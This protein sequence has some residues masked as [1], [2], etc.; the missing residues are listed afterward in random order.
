MDQLK[1]LGVKQIN[2]DTRPMDQ[3]KT[4]GVKQIN[5]DTRPMDQLKTLEV[6][7]E[8]HM[9]LQMLRFMACPV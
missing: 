6:K 1:T 9:E 3:L 5:L 4:L 8:A 7:Q 2:L